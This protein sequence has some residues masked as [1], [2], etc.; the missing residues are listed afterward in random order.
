MINKSSLLAIT[1]LAELAQLSP[2]VCEGASSIARKIDAP[3]NYLGKLL[4]SLA[5]RGLILSQKGRGGGFRLKKKPKKISLLEVVAAMEDIDRW[6][7][8]FLGRKKCLDASPC[9]VHHQWKKVREANRMFLAKIS[10]F[11][12]NR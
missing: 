4:Q 5:S 2:G 12:L 3:A 7:N 1:A 10:L 11:D 6:S 9:R 8:C